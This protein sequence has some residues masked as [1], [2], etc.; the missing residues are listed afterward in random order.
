MARWRGWVRHSKHLDTVA[1]GQ[2]QIRQDTRVVA[3]RQRSLG[4]QALLHLIDRAAV[5]IQGVAQALADHLVVFDQQ[6]TQGS[7]KGNQ[8]TINDGPFFLAGR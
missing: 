7:S 2:A 8:S 4:K 5:G 1:L 3:V 6:D